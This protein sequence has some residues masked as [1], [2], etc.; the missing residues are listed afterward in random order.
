MASLAYRLAIES[1]HVRTD[2]IEI[3]EFPLL[4]ME[5][6]VAGV[7]LTVINGAARIRGFTRDESYFQ[8][9]MEAVAADGN[10]QELDAE[11]P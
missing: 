1:P 4:A 9:I 6:Q 7:P 2:V 11:T 5:Y 10:P 3:A 8:Q